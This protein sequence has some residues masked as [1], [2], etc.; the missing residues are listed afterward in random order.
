[1]R[2]DDRTD[3]LLLLLFLF[4]LFFLFLFPLPFLL[5]LPSAF[6]FSP[7]C[8]FL[9]VVDANN[10]CALTCDDANCD[11]CSGNA[12]LCQTCASGYQAAMFEASWKTPIT[13][14]NGQDGAQTPVN[15]E[16]SC[17]L[18]CNDENCDTCSNPGAALVAASCVGYGQH[19]NIFSTEK[20]NPYTADGITA[21]QKRLNGEGV[22]CTDAGGTYTARTG[23]ATTCESCATGFRID[24][25]SACVP[26]DDTNCDTCSAAANICTN[27]IPGYQVAGNKC[28]LPSDGPAYT[29]GQPGQTCN[30][31]C[32]VSECAGLAAA[33]PQPWMLLTSHTMTKWGLT[34]AGPTDYKWSPPGDWGCTHGGQNGLSSVIV[35]RQPEAC[36]S[37]RTGRWTSVFDCAYR[38]MELQGVSPNGIGYVSDSRQ[39]CPCNC[40][41]RY[42][43][44]MSMTVATCASGSEG[45]KK[46]SVCIYLIIPCT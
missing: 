35:R 25:N 11:D 44:C 33:S 21:L 1:M 40:Q 45:E 32:G 13:F 16:I 8:S 34:L 30:E 31:V 18:I 20:A 42:P 5:P 7:S 38:N 4:F 6:F 39:L 26:C 29:L 46:K 43:K 12:A 2:L 17:K 3:I 27:C 28:V 41:N 37:Q 15:Q 19:A 23:G 36:V 14:V 9:F 22:K 10:A 24:A